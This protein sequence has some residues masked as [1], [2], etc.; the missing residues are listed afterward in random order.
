MLTT[1]Q[2]RTKIGAKDVA[3][4][5]ENNDFS[6]SSFS[7][8]RKD[9]LPSPRLPQRPHFP[10]RRENSLHPAPSP[11]QVPFITPLSSHAMLP[12]TLPQKSHLQMW[13]LKLRGA[14][15]L[16]PSCLG[17]AR[18]RTRSFPTLKSL[19][20]SS[21]AARSLGETPP[22]T[23]KSRVTEPDTWAQTHTPCP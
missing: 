19:L 7:L 14:T 9:S 3:C 13:N 4:G 16:T 18:V 21:Y 15:E 10:G 6:L 17:E 20:H 2:K 23:L 22:Q 5:A 8:R 11:S 1:I 12:Q